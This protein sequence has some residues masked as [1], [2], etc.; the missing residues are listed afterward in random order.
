M[1]GALAIPATIEGKPVTAIGGSAFLSSTRTSISIPATVTRIGPSAFL[2]CLKLTEVNIPQ[3]ITIIEAGTFSVCENLVSVTIPPGVTRIDEGA[4]SSCKRLEKATIPASVTQIGDEAFSGCG[5]LKTIVIPA[6]VRT[7]GD[8]AFAS[9]G[10]RTIEIPATVKMIGK[11]LLTACP[12]LRRVD[13]PSGFSTIGERMFANCSRLTRM[14]I[15]PT[16]TRIEEEAFQ[17]CR[18]LTM[19]T[20]PKQVVEI[21]S[22]AFEDCDSLESVVFTGKAPLLGNDVFAS[23][24]P[25]FKIFIAE[26]A[27]GYTLPKWHGYRTSLP[28]PEIAILNAE[29]SSLENDQ[30]LSKFGGEV[31]GKAGSVHRFT[32]FNA[33]PRKLTGLHA[34]ITGGNS[35]DFI[36]K[37]L[38]KSSLNAGKTTILEIKF[39]PRNTGK[40]VSEL[41][42][43]STDKDE[44]PFVIDLVGT[45]LQLTGMTPATSTR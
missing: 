5:A 9:T 20:I 18:G 10:I 31:V 32:L 44:D 1:G 34:K 16:V 21:G 6:S 29:G 41:W 39:Q 13:F 3:G 2:Y 19:M 33:G 28:T 30:H 37:T 25:D 36:V 27:P 7:L 15:P 17:G 23:T 26:G 12:N 43:M 11:G 45:G 42:I 4:F 8:S 14:T 24:A 35:S 38:P 22:K 40:R